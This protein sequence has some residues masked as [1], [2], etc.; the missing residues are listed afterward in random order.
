[1]KGYC[2]NCAKMESCRKTCGI[3]FGFCSTDFIRK[4]SAQEVK[5]WL[6]ATDG[7]ITKTESG[8]L[9]EWY[10]ESALYKTFA[11]LKED[12]HYNLVELRKDGMKC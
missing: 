5:S 11:E 3:M 10:G 8:Y 7:R 6:S 2:E 4:N 12:A 9:V 1:M